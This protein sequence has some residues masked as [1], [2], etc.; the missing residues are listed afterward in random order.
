MP[1]KNNVTRMLDAKKIAYT[2]HPLPEKKLG[3]VE[4]AEII[5]VSPAIV[6]KTIVV[7]RLERGKPVL[8]VVPGS[9][10]VDLKALAKAVGEKKLKLTTQAEAE[11]LT[12]LQ[13][14]GISPLA[15]LNKGFQ[16]VLD[17][18]AEGHPTIIIS[19]GQWGLNIQLAPQDL[20]KLTNARTAPISTSA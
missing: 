3:A 19:G 10:E 16:T 12:G 20:G 4:V 11:K 13:A 18:S 17:S 15:L 2:P 5:G 6:F 9:S 7:K 8:A 14:G 1:I